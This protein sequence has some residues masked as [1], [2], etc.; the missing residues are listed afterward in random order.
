MAHSPEHVPMSSLSVEIDAQTLTLGRFQQLA[1]SLSGLIREVGDEVS[2]TV[3]D[4]VRWVITDVHHSNLALEL[5]PQRT[6]DNVPPD[7]PDRIADAIASGVAM[8][9][10]R[11]ERPPYFSDKALE[12]AKELANPVGDEV[13]A[14]RIRRRHNGKAGERVTLTKRLVA[15]V[16]EIIG[17]Q[18]QEYGSVEGRLEG[19]MTHGKRRFFIWES[20]TNHRVECQ[21]GDRIPLQDIL[22]AYE[23]RVAARGIVYRR[24]TGEKLSVEVEEFRAFRSEEELPGVQRIQEILRDK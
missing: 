8:I 12:R 13:R 3:R 9:E 2:E 19:L 4:G 11:A 14:V 24:R 1:Q 10:A 18:L 7:L 16:D 5:T 20:L 21:F 15:N 22:A 17:P 6:S 23:R